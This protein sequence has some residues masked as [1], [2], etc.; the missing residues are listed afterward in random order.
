MYPHEDY[1]PGLQP[2]PPVQIPQA[3]P[4]SEKQVPVGLAIQAESS[5]HLSERMIEKIGTYSTLTLIQ[6]LQTTVYFF[7]L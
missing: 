7:L 5:K 3:N 6:S 4:P 2:K 1:H